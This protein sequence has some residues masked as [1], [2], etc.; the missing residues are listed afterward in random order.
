[1]NRLAGV[2]VLILLLMN[3]MSS[4][5]VAQIQRDT[6]KVQLH[7]VT[8]RGDKNSVFFT[9][10]GLVLYIIDSKEITSSPA[11]HLN[12]LLNQIPGLDLRQRGPAGI[13]ADLNVRGSTAE[14][15]GLLVNG[16]DVTDAQTGH[17]N[18]DLA[19]PLQMIERI[20]VLSGTAARLAG[21]PMMAGAVNI[22]TKDPQKSALLAGYSTGSFKYH[23][24]QGE[25]SYRT[26]MF[27]QYLGGE[28]Q[29]ANGYMNNTDFKKSS[30]FYQTRIETDHTKIHFQAGWEHKAFGANAFY[31][32][33]YPNQ[34]EEISSSFSSVQLRHEGRI[35]M[36][37]D[38]AYRTHT[39][40]FELF[41]DQ[42][43][44]WY[45]HHN[46]HFTQ[47]VTAHTNFRWEN[48][49]GPL[50]AGIHFRHDWIWSTVLGEPTDNAK[51]VVEEAD[52]LYDHFA[53]RSQGGF[54]TNQHVHHGRWSLD[55]GVTMNLYHSQ[56]FRLQWFPGISFEYLLHPNFSWTT[57]FERSFRLPNFTEMYYQSLTHEGDAGLQ[58]EAGW[59]FE[60]GIRRN[61]RFAGWKAVTFYR[62]QS[63]S[64]DWIRLPGESVWHAANL[65][66]MKTWGA[67]GSFL[68]RLKQLAPKMNIPLIFQGGIQY[69]YQISN[70]G[71]YESKYL[72]DYLKL[73]WNLQM[74]SELIRGFRLTVQFRGQKRAGT[75]TDYSIPD[76][77]LT[78]VYPYFILTDL[79]CAKVFKWLTFFVECTNLENVRYIDLG[80][81]PQPGRWLRVGIAV[82]S[83]YF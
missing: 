70:T 20:E 7:P 37:A 33:V 17:F 1:M 19:I 83:S 4:Q 78:V 6:S 26:G 10:S 58:P 66:E 76:A 82:F 77:P 44:Q 45:K 47:A 41:R 36:N 50:N 57:Q 11:T 71:K 24:L 23:A 39:D 54:S 73:K 13:Q 55:A 49:L 43:P 35:T 51:P 65:G 34:F 67:E 63:E 15:V 12:D 21:L 69:L 68:L 48:R 42:A 75:Y 64:L 79:K 25:I 46:Y 22:I 30:L 32:P 62:F 72:H 9:E 61:N 31:T 56:R 27:S 29:Q 14:Q 8:I 16:V 28:W 52:I 18:L 80:N 2:G 60:T 59:Q 74:R 3:A 53:G 81:I 5:V 38:F 40:R